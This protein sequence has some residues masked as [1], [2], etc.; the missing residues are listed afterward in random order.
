MEI[1]PL[2][3]LVGILFLPCVSVLNF[4]EFNITSNESNITS[5]SK[6]LELCKEETFVTKSFKSCELWA[7]I[8]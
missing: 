1:L 2:F 8:Q 3:E 4:H 5:T 7:Y 6:C